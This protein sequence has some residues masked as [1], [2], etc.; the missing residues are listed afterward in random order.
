MKISVCH[1]KCPS[2]CFVCMNEFNN[3]WFPWIMIICIILKFEYF[4]QIASSLVE[5]AFATRQGP[6]SARTRVP[7]LLQDVCFWQS[8]LGKVFFLQQLDMQEEKQIGQVYLVPPG[9]PPASSFFAGG[10]TSWASV[11][12]PPCFSSSEFFSA[13]GPAGGGAGWT[14]GWEGRT[15]ASNP[16]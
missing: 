15:K 7:G 12:C 14:G 3:S 1:T 4:P 11:P 5:N 10:E 9:S 8:H 16:G 13:G 6:L 2:I